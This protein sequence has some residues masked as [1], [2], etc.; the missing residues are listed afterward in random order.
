[1]KFK[2]LL[3]F[4]IILRLS[5]SAQELPPNPV[6]N[7]VDS[8]VTSHKKLFP[9]DSLVVRKPMTEN[10]VFSKR[11]DENYRKKYK[12]SEFDYTTVKPKESVWQKIMKR[13]RKIMEAIFGKVDPNKAM[14]FTETMLRIFAVVIAGF[15]LYFLIKFLIGRDGNFFFSKKNKK[16]NIANQDLN[17]N[18]HEINFTETI[19]QFERQQDYRSAV[20]YQFLS[21]L[22]KL[23]DEKLINWNPEK[24]NQDYLVELK[25]SDFEAEFKELAH[26]FDYVWYGEF[27]VN[28]E[29]Y[30]HF[31]QQFLNFK[32]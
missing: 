29:N 27:E 13:V 4:F 2:I 16:V 26:I 30:R 14:S 1:M 7:I 11:F 18:I 22:K 21:V 20:R 31:K 19:A 15:V 3:L 6:S 28:E 23:A 32:R 17:E 8:A 25:S 24:T 9:T 5:G 12:S 10:T